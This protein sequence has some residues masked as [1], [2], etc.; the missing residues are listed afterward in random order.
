MSHYADLVKV[1]RSHVWSVIRSPFPVYTGPETDAL[2]L[3]RSLQVGE[4]MRSNAVGSRVL[5]PSRRDKHTRDPLRE[6]HA[7]LTPRY[8]INQRSAL[9]DSRQMDA[10]FAGAACNRYTGCII[11]R[12]NVR[13]ETFHVGCEPAQMSRQNDDAV[14]SSPVITQDGPCY[15]VRM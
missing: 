13:G 4:D 11:R 15:S 10:A 14:P 3:T 2:A 12:V 6:E 1:G 5:P 7:T 9:G 8:D